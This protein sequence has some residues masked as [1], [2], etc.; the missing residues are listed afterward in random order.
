MEDNFFGDDR[1]CGH[2]EHD[3]AGIIHFFAEDGR[4]CRKNKTE[5]HSDQKKG[6][7]LRGDRVE[8]S[9]AIGMCFIS[10]PAG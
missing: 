6:D 2:Y 7:Q 1:N 3:E 9:V 5:T 8:F 10:R 4:T